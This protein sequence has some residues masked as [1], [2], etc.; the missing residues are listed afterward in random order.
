[1]RVALTLCCI[2]LEQ[3]GG[4]G[5]GCLVYRDQRA[6]LADDLRVMVRVGRWIGGVKRQGTHAM[7]G[8]T[9]CMFWAGLDGPALGSSIVETGF[10]D[11]ERAAFFVRDTHGGVGM[12]GLF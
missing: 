1:M 5:S 9:D 11:G 6:R 2:S 12:G 4:N 3:G 8:L 10:W 7:R